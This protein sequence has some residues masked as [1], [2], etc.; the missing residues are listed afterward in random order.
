MAPE[1]VEWVAGTVPATAGHLAA[2]GVLGAGLPGLRV[3]MLDLDL[4]PLGERPE[5]FA[6]NDRLL[7]LEQPDLDASGFTADDRSFLARFIGTPALYHTPALAAAFAAQARQNI[8]HVL[9]K[10]N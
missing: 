3:W 7:R 4:T 2:A 8:A 6:R 10:A 5:V 1:D 9:T